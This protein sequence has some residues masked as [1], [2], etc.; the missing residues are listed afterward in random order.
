MIYVFV[1]ILV[2]GTVA[3]LVTA[4]AQRRKEQTDQK[5]RDRVG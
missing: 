2:F 4:M 1:A 3:T 5:L